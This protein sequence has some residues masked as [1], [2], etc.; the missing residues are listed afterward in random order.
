MDDQEFRDITEAARQ[1]EQEEDRVDLHHKMDGIQAGRTSKHEMAAALQ[2]TAQ[3]RKRKREEAVQVFLRTLEAIIRDGELNAHIAETVFAA[4]ND[5]EIADIVLRIERETGQPL[6]NYATNILGPK[7]AQR[8][9]GESDADYNRRMIMAVASE[10]IDPQTGRIKPQYASDPLAQIILSD[11]AY[12][13]IM[14]EIEQ[15]NQR[16]PSPESDAI[17][18]QH[19]DAGYESSELF[20]HYVEDAGYKNELRGGQK[21]HR[22]DDL[23]VESATVES[24]IFFGSKNVM[25]QASSAARQS[26]NAVV[27]ADP[28]KGVRLTGLSSTPLLGRKA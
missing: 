3:D 6:T 22:D 28:D 13:Q 26:F 21:E 20:G 15:V 4:K 2:N 7:T 10:I 12:Q 5:A 18:A 17:V 24:E 9:P 23:S 8:K 19:R 27:Q 14:V 11:T 16:G 1:R 25:K